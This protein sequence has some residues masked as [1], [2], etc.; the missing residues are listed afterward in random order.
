MFGTAS[1]RCMSLA[2]MALPVF[3]RAPDTAQLLLP[4]VASSS[5]GSRAHQG[6]ESPGRGSARRSNREVLPGAV[7]G[8]GPAPCRAHVEDVGGRESAAPDTAR[9]RSDSPSR[10]RARPGTRTAA[11]A[12]TSCI[13]PSVCLVLPLRA[14][15]RHVHRDRREHRVF[16]R[17]RLRRGAQHQVLERRRR[18]RRQ[19]GVDAGGVGVELGLVVGRRVGERLAG[20]VRGSGARASRGRRSAPPAPTSADSSPAG[21][22]RCRSIW[23]NRSCAWTNPTARARSTRDCALMVGTPSAS[24]VTVTGCDSPASV[25]VPSV[26]GRLRPSTIRRYPPPATVTTTT[27]AMTRSEEAQD[28]AAHGLCD[29]SSPMRRRG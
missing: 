2:T 16:R 22:R 27:A 15:Q 20:D 8:R 29:P 4:S 18:Q 5:R 25:S 13:A 28:V 21:W 19:P 9:R 14:L 24:R 6:G 26:T 10:W 12:A 7:L 17:P 1:R 3:E 11:R 23:K